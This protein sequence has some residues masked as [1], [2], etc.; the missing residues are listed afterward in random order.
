MAVGA[1]AKGGQRVLRRRI[2]LELWRSIWNFRM[3]VLAALA[4]LVLAKVAS[5]SVPLLL[6]RIVDLFSGPQQALLLPVFLLLAYAVV[7]FGSNVFNELRDVVFSVVTRRTVADFMQRTF[8]HLH[9]LGARFH[10]RRETGAVIR[11]LEK[12]TGGIGFLLG[13]AV[14][15]I[16][17]TLLEIAAVLFIII[18]KYSVGF[19]VIILVTFV[20]YATYTVIFTRRRM[21]Y[22]RHVNALEAQS[23]GRVVD[24]LLNYDTVKYFAREDFETGRLGSVLDKWVTAGAANQ[25]ALSTLHIGQSACIGAGI[26]A[27][28]LLAGQSV[29][30]G[31]MTVGDL[32]LINAYIIQVSLPLNSLGFV[33]RETNDAMTNIER[34]FALLDARGKEGE[35]ADA[36][37]ARP[38]QPGAGEIVFENVNFSYEP[39][40]Q[41]LWN[42]SFRIEP[43]QTVAVVGGSGSGKSTLARLL[44]RLY[45]PDSGSIRIDGQDLRMVTQHSL[46]EAIGIVP[47]DTILFNETLA[48]NIAYG[49]QGASRA[50]VVEAA[51]GAQ[52]EPF[53]ERLP[54]GYDT[55]V[56]ERGVRLSGGERQRVAIAR[57]LLKR[58]PIMVFDEATSALDT[59]SER[60]IQAELMRVARG[61]TSLVIAH[62]LSTIVDA[63]RI[64]VMEHGRIVERGAHQELLE[65]KGMY[66]QMW[67]LQQQQR[68]LERIEQRLARQPIQLE[69]LAADVVDGLREQ[70]AER[71][72]NVY[73][74]VGEAELRVTGDPSVLQKVI[75]DLCR[76][77]VENSGEGGRIELRLNRRNDQ[78]HLSIT[79]SG[80]QPPDLDML[81]IAELEGLLESQRGK[82]TVRAGEHGATFDIELPLRAIT[83]LRS[84]SSDARPT[85]DRRRNRLNGVPVLALDG[86]DEERDA[87]T[88]VLT[89]AGARLTSME[90]GKELLNW[91]RGTPPAQ[92]PKALVC[93]TALAD[94]DGYAVMRQV[95]ELEGELGVPLQQR[96]PAIAISGYAQTRERVHA[97][98]AGFQMNLAKPVKA[99]ELVGAVAGLVTGKGELDERVPVE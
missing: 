2:A 14:F 95:R 96:M 58:P 31:A 68:E 88:A 80:G 57:A 65:K 35:D 1:A 78:A 36:D 79:S 54:D 25:Y 98:M 45:Q 23:N 24:S 92:W 72:V 75:W 11:D 63:D 87:M 70:I 16:V 82:L 8:S 52:L 84:G 61:R 4:L 55:R 74:Q 60:A 21:R 41:I 12:G 83:D 29:V 66:A 90:T 62:R 15:T 43:G 44:F 86:S 30:E 69:V 9:H 22:Q 38:L 20:C 56:G 34:L 33:F 50:D 19:T 51:R 39:G 32:I 18:G 3:R 46:R 48:Y 7:R 6:K 5:V 17:P 27:V 47:Q 13:V 67:A 77:A 91:L 97:L 59:R 93:D 81:D 64:L 26:A 99:E 28:M 40:R 94:E 76:Q 73:T 49:R 37:A 85:V 89:D 42:V 10:S 53:I 71:R